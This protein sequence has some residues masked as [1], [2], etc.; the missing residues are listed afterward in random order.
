[1]CVSADI[2]VDFLNDNFDLQDFNYLTKS[3]TSGTT[4]Q[5]SGNCFAIVLFGIDRTHD[6]RAFEMIKAAFDLF[7]DKE[8][9][10]LSLP[11][12]TQETAL[13]PYFS[14]APPRT[15]SSK[16][17]R[18]PANFSHALYVFQRDSIRAF[19]LRYMVAETPEIPWWV[20]GSQLKVNHSSDRSALALA[21]HEALGVRCDWL[22][23]EVEHKVFAVHVLDTLVGVVS[24]QH[25]VEEERLEALQESFELDARVAPNDVVVV[26]NILLSPVFLKAARQIFQHILQRCSCLCLMFK[27]PPSAPLPTSISEEFAQ[28]RPRQYAANK[29]E[30]D[31]AI[32]TLWK[33]EL[34]L[35]TYRVSTRVVVAG[36]SDAGLALLQELL[37]VRHICFKNLVLLTPGAVEVTHPDLKH[38]LSNGACNGPMSRDCLGRTGI[39]SRVR[40][41]NGKVTGMDRRENI[42]FL[43]D[44]TELFFDKLILATGRS[45]VSIP[46]SLG[47]PSPAR[48]LFC[49]E[50]DPVKGEQLLT[51]LK[52]SASLEPFDPV[53][54][55]GSSVEALAAIS[56]MTAL[57]KAGHAITLVL[58]EPLTHVGFD[59][60]VADVVTEQLLSA[61]IRLYE[62]AS[63]TNSSFAEGEINAITLSNGEEISVTLLL[64]AGELEVDE[65]VCRAVNEGGAVYDA[66]VVVNGGLETV[67]EGVYAIGPVARFSRR[68]QQTGRS[69]S[70]FDSVAIAASAAKALLRRIDPLQKMNTRNEVNET[71][72]EDYGS[73]ANEVS[74]WTAKLCCRGSMLPGGLEYFTARVPEQTERNPYSCALRR[75]ELST[76]QG[77][78]YLRLTVNAFGF[79]EAVTALIPESSGIKASGLAY[80]V[81]THVSY[82]NDV[83]G[84]LERGELDDLLEFFTQDWAAAMRHDGFRKLIDSMHLSL[85]QTIDRPL[86]SAIQKL[87]EGYEGERS[88]LDLR[89]L[90]A[91]VVGVGGETLNAPESR[92]VI[93]SELAEFLRSHQSVLNMYAIGR[94]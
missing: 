72:G 45:S 6:S 61:D 94:C 54:I 76:R 67:R 34:S 51:A 66:G 4:P 87:Q 80:L 15:C 3:L 58:P 83:E 64:L 47:T 33:A 20:N 56:L 46:A 36:A 41:V 32:F 44:N 31:C 53:V 71:L 29:P 11:H 35:P 8:Y 40:W 62:N 16:R 7:P 27:L 13:T 70:D 59:D 50:A 49:I 60:V 81:G 21:V 1:M 86:E 42:A 73:E 25:G 90:K 78:R 93:E 65:G 52:K 82:L 88:A 69:L 92:E 48:N 19:D 9:C 74:K 37:L 84:K 28:V 63:I 23:E 2:D 22:M 39:L 85:G 77:L 91:D 24:V 79:V 55:Y 10:T 12:D 18:D 89:L 26:H 14:Y 68:C 17:G 30:Y 75:R 5:Q 38:L 57:G 43:S